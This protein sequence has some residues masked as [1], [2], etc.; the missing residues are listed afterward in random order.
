[1]AALGRA[2]IARI[3]SSIIP[4]MPGKVRDLWFH[5]AGELSLKD[6]KEFI[7]VLLWFYTEFYTVNLVTNLY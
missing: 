4:S 5:D 7:C 6:V 2:L 1:M 3:E